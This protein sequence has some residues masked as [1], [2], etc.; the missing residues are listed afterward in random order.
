VFLGGKFASTVILPASNLNE[1]LIDPAVAFIRAHGGVIRLHEH[2]EQL[3]F[4]DDG[5]VIVGTSQ[6][7]TEASSAISAIPAMAL[8][9]V[10]LRSGLQER[11]R[12]D[13]AAFEDAPIV[14]AHFFAPVQLAREPML[15]ILGSPLQ[16]LFSKG[17]TA[18]GLWRYSCTISAADALVNSGEAALRAM[19]TSELCRFFPSLTSA[20][21]IRMKIVKERAATFLPKPG[22]DAHRPS[23][24]TSIPNFF[25]AGDW[26]DT[27][28][29]ATIEG[30]VRS[31]MAAARTFEGIVGKQGRVQNAEKNR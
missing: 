27:G 13:T 22:I 19:I 4:R 7:A 10:L 26:T 18:S 2:V 31:G 21:I 8:S 11:I 24:R 12:F 9:R 1:T 29:P 23:A 5:S 20:R 25:L 6:D 17:Q 16:W 14:S 28:L 15:G 3:S 30:A